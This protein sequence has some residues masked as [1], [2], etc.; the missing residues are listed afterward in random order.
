[1]IF[2]LIVLSP[3][4][5]CPLQI[6]SL[7]KRYRLRL[8]EGNDPDINKD[9]KMIVE[10]GGLNKT[11]FTDKLHISILNLL[12]Q[13]HDNKSQCLYL[14]EGFMGENNFQTIG[15]TLQKYIRDREETG[16]DSRNFGMLKVSGDEWVI[17]NAEFYDPLSYIN[18]NIQKRLLVA[19]DS[20]IECGAEP[21]T[22]VKGI[23]I[24]PR[25][26]LQHYAELVD[27]EG[28]VYP[29]LDDPVWAEKF[30]ILI[31]AQM[32]IMNAFYEKENPE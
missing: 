10:T 15:A 27:Q 14:H 5:D 31:S 13:F 12:F 4:S 25:L 1:M 32:E 26:I 19:A 17:Y 11:R 29:W 20:V 30:S 16:A 22:D 3:D 8:F 2:D 6:A 28:L 24:T 9:S 7:S 18:T 21:I 23:E